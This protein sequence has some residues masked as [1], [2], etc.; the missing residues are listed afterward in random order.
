MV[1][2]HSLALTGAAATLLASLPLASVYAH[3]TW[4]FYGAVT[5]AAVVGAASAVRA[6]RGAAWLQVL[7]MI[8]GLVLAVTVLFPS[9]DEIARFVPTQATFVN[10]DILLRQAGAEVR[11]S[12]APVQDLD[13]LLLVTTLGIGLVAMLVDL[14]AVGIR[15]PALAGLPMLAI[16]SVPVAVLPTSVSLWWFAAAATGYLWLLVSDS[17]DRVRRFGR[18][19]SGEGRD[20]EV[21]EPSPLSAAG[22]RLGVAGLVLAIVVPLAIPVMSSGI[23]KRLG[24]LAGDGPGGEA[25]GGVAAT[26]D[27]NALLA[28][29]LTRRE[30]FAMLTISTDEQNPYYLRIGTAEEIN[31]SGFTAATPSSGTPLSRL[32]GPPSLA[33]GM[34]RT[35]YT[36]HVEIANLDL[37]LAPI[38]PQIAAV[39]GLDDTWR[40]DESTDQLFSRSASIDDA[41]YDFDYYRMI[42]T[43]EGLRGARPVEGI[44]PKLTQVPAIE[45]V[46]QIVND[47]VGGIDNQYDAVRALYEWFSPRNGF[48]YSLST[49]QGNSGSDIVDFLTNK[50]GFCV[51][52]AAALTW[53]VR[54]AGYPARVAFGFTRGARSSSGTVTLTNHN[55][56]AWTEV[57]FPGYGWVPFDATPG[58]AVVGSTTTAWAPDTTQA[59]NTPSATAG[60]GA[61]AGPNATR[62]PRD[63]DQ[64]DVDIPLPGDS[65]VPLVTW[66]QVAAAVAVLVVIILLLAP[67]ARRRA[68]RNRRRAR[69]GNVIALTP[70]PPGHEDLVTD[71]A[72]MTQAQ[73]DA[74]EAWAELLDT[75]I[76]YGVLVDPAET[77]R[78]TAGRLRAT[79]QLAPS[80]HGQTTVLARAE[81]R[82]RYAPTPVRPDNLDE[83]VRQARQAF[84]ERATRWQRLSAALFPRSVLLRWRLGWYA[85]AGRIVGRATRVR[86]AVLLVG[87]RSRRR[88]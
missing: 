55:L 87:W 57:Y 56:H 22:R 54:A 30:E 37:R 80:G 11:R 68:L 34:S 9:G 73:R 18:R 12:A 35:R 28:D 50:R 84:A 69:V 21:W 66:W 63:P 2:R 29:N 59:T 1:R 42:Y 64:G 83:A 4:L 79:P 7:G 78:A 10:F 41:R 26:V 6:L 62:D 82:A 88:R 67:S 25:A 47:V 76:D 71:P 85:F 31:G 60:P 14:A 32:P 40:L 39:A 86:D 61:T 46:S 38:Y 74:H 72:A 8:A 51:Q 70:A 23:I 5:V 75:M 49:V 58:A 24:T 20:V 33:S 13:G 17:V 3:F 16:Y 77:P 27:M 36:A 65:A 43:P 15:R 44:D 52:Y 81:E 19:F 48:A 45:Y 53:L